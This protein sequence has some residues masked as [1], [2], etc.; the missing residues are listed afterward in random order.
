MDDSKWCP[1]GKGGLRKPWCPAGS[2]WEKEIVNDVKLACAKSL[3]ELEF[4]FNYDTMT[5]EKAVAVIEATT[6][7]LKS[8]ARRRSAKAKKKVLMIPA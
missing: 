8:K 4:D 7:L 1:N 6:R 2:D 3:K 5:T